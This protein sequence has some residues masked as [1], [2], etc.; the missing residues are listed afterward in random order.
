[1]TP[2]R[3]SRS[4][5]RRHVVGVIGWP[6]E[7]SLSPA[8]HNAAFASLGM[9]WVYVPL[10][11]APGAMR[12]AA[13][14]LVGLGF[15]GAN[16]TMPHKTESAEL[17]D[18]LS[19]D[20]RRLARGQ[21]VR[22]GRRPAARVTTPT[23]P[24][25]IGSCGATPGST[26]RDGR[27]WCSARAAPL[28]R[29]RS[30]WRSRAPPSCASPCGTPGA[31]TT[32]SLAIEGTELDVEVV[33]VR[34]GGAAAAADLV[35]NA[36]PLGA[37]GRSC[38]PLPALAPGRARRRPPLPAGGDAA[39][40]ARPGG[41]GRDVRGTGAAAA[42]GGALVRAVDRHAG[43]ARRDVG[44]RRRGRSPSTA[45]RP[46]AAPTVRTGRPD[47]LKGGRHA[48]DAAREMDDYSA[49]AQ[50]ISVSVS[51]VSGAL[52]LSRDGLV[53]GAYP[54]EDESLAKPAWLKFITL[55]EP[56]RS[57]VE[58]PDQV[59]AYVKR[60]RTP[61]SPRRRPEP[62]PASSST[63][64]NR[65]SWSPRRDAPGATRCAFPT[66]TR[67]RRANRAPRSI[68]RSTSR[69]GHHRGGHGRCSRAG[70]DR[71]TGRPIAA[72]SRRTPGDGAPRRRRAISRS[73]RA[74]RR[75]RRRPRSGGPSDAEE[76]AAEARRQGRRIGL[77]RG[78]RGRP[79]PPGQRV[80]GI[81]SG[82]LGR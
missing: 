63:R 17:A 53:L 59:W 14:G 80:L 36:T 81:A 24:G 2:G 37:D 54:N 33:A 30:R 7:H 49:L 65:C 31:P 32:C 58:F 68:H 45:D 56:D 19:E 67:P 35:V 60:G 39:A 10:P 78:R 22:R 57:F 64:W 1:M 73:L 50:R 46:P 38:P 28:E 52:I 41:G 44:G 9:D 13:D 12:A 43:A 69:C 40:G 51:G 34:C 70:R 66:R 4:G 47:L 79:G 16:V 3:P 5:E 74:I 75:E 55:G 21:H 82:G 26:R 29:S 77:R 23:R 62:V 18:E 8:I 76:E 72:G 25:S 15:R 61:R 48:V 27:R 11:V 42:S 71:P 20:A 6:V